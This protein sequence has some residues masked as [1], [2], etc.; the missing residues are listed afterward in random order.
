[1]REDSFLV[2]KVSSRMELYNLPKVPFREEWGLWEYSILNS[3]TWQRYSFLLLH[4]SKC[5][6]LKKGKSVTL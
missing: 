1:M 4:R 3:C 6:Y 2:N 5:L